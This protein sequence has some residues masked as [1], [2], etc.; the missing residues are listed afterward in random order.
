MA[1]VHDDALHLTVEE[2]WERLVDGEARSRLEKVLPSVLKRQR[3]FG[4]KS[5][6]LTAAHIVDA[7][8]ISSDRERAIILFIDVSY[9]D[10]TKETYLMPVATAFGEEA[11]SIAR[12]MP[13]AVLASVTVRGT[14]PARQGVLYDAVRN[15]R[16]AQ[17]L[18]QAIG[19]DSR[20]PGRAGS[21]VASRTAL[22][23]VIVPAEARLDARV[24]KAEQSNTS[25][26]YGDR[27]IL[28]LYR[29][30]QPG[31]NPDLEIGRYL[32]SVAFP[33]SPP[34]GG[35]IEYVRPGSEPMTVCLLHAFVPNQGDAWSAFLDEADAFVSRVSTFGGERKIANGR[36]L[37]ERV[38]MPLPDSHRQLIGPAW[39]AAACLGRRTAALHLALARAEDPA[40][41]PE[42]FTEEYRRSRYESMMRLWSD[43]RFL[44]AQRRA[45]F[46]TDLQ[47][48]MDQLLDREGDIRACGQTFFNLQSAGMRIRCHGDYHLGQVLWTGSDYMIT[49]FEGEPARPLSERRMK[50]SPLYDVAGMLR[51]FDYASAVVLARREPPT[52]PELE[53]W[54]AFWS[55]TLQVEF[56]KAYLAQAQGASFWPPPKDAQVL[57]RVH[58]LEKAIYELGYELNNRPEWAAIPLRGLFTILS[59][60]GACADG[61]SDQ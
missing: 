61:V 30:M 32:T 33:H 26:V 6:P 22:Y 16:I 28:K 19:E 27:A 31:V 12:K 5:R 60:G 29:R 35:S 56:V 49:D 46:R 8:P 2:A 39:E 3:W 41:S 9:S 50:H 52:A 14:G 4:G 44:L 37:W 51:S 47:Q 55:S 57:L 21:L 36:S 24:M 43:T 48:Q 18:L 42:P 7:L 58:L 1:A 23:R 25:L 34:I 17:A 40:M 10:G 45:T 38:R 59:M 15:G 54:A 11:K 20:V 53:S 13:E